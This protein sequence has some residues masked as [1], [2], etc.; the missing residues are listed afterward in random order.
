MFNEFSGEQP[1]LKLPYKACQDNDTEKFLCRIAGGPGARFL[2]R[3][4]HDCNKGR[5]SANVCGTLEQCLPRLARLNQIGYG[6]FVIVNEST[7]TTD[8]TVTDVRAVFVDLDGIELADRKERLKYFAGSA[9]SVNIKGTAGLAP[10]SMIV[11]SSPG[12]YHT[13]L[14][15]PR[16][17]ALSIQIGSTG[18]CTRSRR[19]SVRM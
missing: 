12:R 2:F 14:A 19:R 13:L 6:I 17:A 7:G 1:T 9:I 5:P 16:D 4:I 11:E 3:A 8:G 10:I 15:L 18:A